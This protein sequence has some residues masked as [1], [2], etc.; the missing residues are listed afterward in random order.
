MNRATY[1]V[2]LGLGEEADGNSIPSIEM[3]SGHNVSPA[4]SREEANELL[5][6]IR[7]VIY[8]HFDRTRRLKMM[9]RLDVT[10]QR[11]NGRATQPHK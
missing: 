2:F 8:E 1:Y 7:A 9:R 3:R 10:C 11:F 4:M 5:A 6:E